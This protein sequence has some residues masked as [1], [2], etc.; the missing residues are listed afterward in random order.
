MGSRISSV[1]SE[2]QSLD[3]DKYPN[4][5]AAL[6]RVVLELAVTE[7][8]QKKKWPEGKLRDMVRKCVD[9]LDPTGKSPMYQPVRAG[10]GDG[11]SVFSVRTIHAYLHN[12]HFNPTPSEL[13]NASANYSAFLA[14]LDTLI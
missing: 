11:S 14:G 5:A 12:Q 9:A 3:V 7:V 8:H 6:T 10:L 1:L 13:T 4:A 2:L